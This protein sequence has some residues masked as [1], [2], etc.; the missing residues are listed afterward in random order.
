RDE[1]AAL[2][3]SLRERG[4]SAT[5]DD[6]ARELEARDK[7]LSSQLDDA[8]RQAACPVADGWTEA[9][10]LLAALDTAPDQEAARLR[11]RAALRRIIGEIWVFIRHQGKDAM[12]VLQVYFA[13]GGSP[14]TFFVFHRPPRANTRGRKPGH[15]LAISTKHKAE[16]PD[17][18]QCGKDEM[19]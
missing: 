17:M 15:W 16:V 14:R 3:K 10:S 12:A 6:R 19:T 4:F 2:R 18:R 8:S 13:G 5:L 1:L 9:K 11:L 7:Q